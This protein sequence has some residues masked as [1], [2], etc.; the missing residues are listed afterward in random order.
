MV[1]KTHEE[2]FVGVLKKYD[3]DKG[4]TRFYNARAWYPG[5]N[6]ITD[7]YCKTLEEAKRVL[8][9]AYKLWNG[10]KLYNEKG[11]RYETTEAAPGIGVSLVCTKETDEDHR[12]VKHIIRRRVVTEW[13]V[14]EEG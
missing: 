3:A 6:S 14:V 7:R 13:E 1:M 11:E 9:H 8:A 10:V 2:Y 12:I 4:E 5:V